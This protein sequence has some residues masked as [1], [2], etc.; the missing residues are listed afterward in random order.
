MNWL[1]YMWD[2][3]P[4]L[5]NLGNKDFQLSKL[6]TRVHRLRKKVVKAQIQLAQ[7]YPIHAIDRETAQL[8]VDERISALQ[9]VEHEWRKEA[10]IS[11]KLML[12]VI[13][14][15]SAIK[16]I[17]IDSGQYI[18]FEGN[19][20]LYALKGVFDDLVIEVDLYQ[21]EKDTTI[22]RR[23]QRILALNKLSL[24]K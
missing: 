13:P 20:R 16:V 24:G 12:A 5:K 23:I 7:L 6:V 11:N 1:L 22:S 21:L 9:K 18:A 15:V 14:S 4:E 2:K 8:R 17:Q 10:F 19:G 3:L